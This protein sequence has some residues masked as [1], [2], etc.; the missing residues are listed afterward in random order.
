VNR[1]AY[2]TI[3]DAPRNDFRKKLAFLKLL[4]IP[5]VFYCTGES[6]M[7]KPDDAVLALKEGYVIG[8]HSYS[9]LH[10][11]SLTFDQAC[12]EI[13]KTDNLLKEIYKTAEKK[14]IRTFRF[15]Y[16]DKGWGDDPENTQPS[17]DEKFFHKKIQDFLREKGYKQPEF[18]GLNYEHYSEK[19]F[20]E[21]I[22]V[23][24]TYDC[25]EWEYDQ[26]D[27]MFNSILE[28]MD[29]DD[30][31]NW[32]GLNSGTSAEIIL[33]HDHDETTVIFELLIKKLVSKGFIFKLPE[34]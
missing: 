3:D 27:S 26:T 7:Q 30:P 32:F 28:R 24:W 11:S 6:L 33:T 12:V 23:F 22:D 4:N 19:N 10:F 14:I 31:G 18:P 21:D 15:P 29:V 5:A 2:L 25:R 8:N 17:L 1:I 16:G 9:H 34:F 20:L 13:E